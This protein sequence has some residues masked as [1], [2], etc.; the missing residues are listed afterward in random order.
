LRHNRKFIA[1]LDAGYTMRDT[2][3]GIQSA[4][5]VS[6]IPHQ[7][8]SDMIRAGVL[9]AL[10][11]AACDAARAAALLKIPIGS[12]ETLDGSTALTIRPAI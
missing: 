12:I 8:K 4:H 2:G 5:L 7:L 3:Y 6:R 10:P 9:L 11:A 1:V